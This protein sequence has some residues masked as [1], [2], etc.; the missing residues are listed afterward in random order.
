[1]AKERT[2]SFRPVSSIISLAL[3]TVVVVLEIV[4]LNMLKKGLPD[5]YSK[6]FG[7]FFN[8]I[9]MLFPTIICLVISTVAA[10]SNIGPSSRAKGN[11]TPILRILGIITFILNLIVIVINGIMIYMLVTKNDAFYQWLAKFLQT[12]PLNIQ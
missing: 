10:I 5:L 4:G 9:I 2:G 8:A 6:S 12:V 1:M 11:A 7:G 3:I